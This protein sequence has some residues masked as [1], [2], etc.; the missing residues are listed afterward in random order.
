MKKIYYII[1]SFCFIF[2]A[3]AEITPYFSPV[4]GGCEKP[5]IEHFEKA[6]DKIDIAVYAI[7]NKNITEAIKK[8]YDRG[9]D[10]KVLTDASQAEYKLSTVRELYNY[11]LD[12]K[13]N[14]KHR[15]M[16]NKYVIFDDNVLITGSFNWTY[17]A[18]YKNSENCMVI[19]QEPELIAKY[20]KD[21][22][23]LWKINTQEQSKLWFSKHNK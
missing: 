4:N 12:V 18:A 6:Q 2:P 7:T 3:V 10:V 20:I 22:N 8:A 5:I 13:V 16:H 15:L 19:T 1:I 9:V 14:S 23:H 21:F 17:S 11:G